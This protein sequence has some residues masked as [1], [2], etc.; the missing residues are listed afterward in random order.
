MITTH[1]PDCGRSTDCCCNP[2]S[3]VRLTCENSECCK[4]IPRVLC[5][6]FV[7]DEPSATNPEFSL[8]SDAGVDALGPASYAIPL[9]Y[10]SY[11]FVMQMER[12]P[13]GGYEYDSGYGSGHQEWA[14]FW[15]I[16]KRVAN[17]NSLYELH[18]IYWKHTGCGETK[19]SNAPYPNDDDGENLSGY[20][21]IITCREF[22]FTHRDPDS[23][24]AGTYVITPFHMHRQPFHSTKCGPEE[25]GGDG[26]ECYAELAEPCDECTQV[27]RRLCLEYNYFDEDENEQTAKRRFDWFPDENNPHGGYWIDPCTEDSISISSYVPGSGEDCYGLQEGDCIVNF[28][29]AALTD[30]GGIW[31]NGEPECPLKLSACSDGVLLRYDDGYGRWVRL[32]AGYCD[33]WDYHCG[34]CR[35]VCPALCYVEVL[36]N[37]NT[38]DVVPLKNVYKALPWD[39]DL[40]GWTDGYDT[41]LLVQTCNGCAIRIEGWD[42]IPVEICGHKIQF[43]AEKDIGSFV[44]GACKGC[45]PCPPPVGCCGDRIL[46]TTLHADLLGY[47]EC[48]TIGQPCPA[49]TSFELN[50]VPTFGVQGWLE[51]WVGVAQVG[52]CRLKLIV[53]CSQ[54][55]LWWWQLYDTDGVVV[56]DSRTE[57]LVTLVDSTCD[58]AVSAEWEFGNDVFICD[59][60]CFLGYSLFISE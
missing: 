60:F 18:R 5:V 30:P 55:S 58:P 8:F 36:Y 19:Y 17:V 37:D 53:Y 16:Y 26:S 20:D 13:L 10:S 39:E 51:R 11:D 7:P 28:D 15:V 44:G 54:E 42:D 22:T 3:L 56:A 27:R 59:W 35:C 47:G 21:N 40:G 23:T 32:S 9:R 4:C 1:G 6:R 46:P 52:D 50:W 38:S 24:R 45:G 14:C 2:C 12:R 57:P 34:K 25:Y 49:L 43:Y 31:A 33:C 48:T 41:V 29:I